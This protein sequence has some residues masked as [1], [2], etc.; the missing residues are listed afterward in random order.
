MKEK[1][2]RRADRS[3]LFFDETLADRQVAADVQRWFIAT[4][5]PAGTRPQLVRKAEVRGLPT[6]FLIGPDG[7][8]LDRIVGYRGAEQF[9]QRLR[10]AAG[11]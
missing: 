6:T 11:D 2:R 7:Q 10:L 9:C 8:I 3:P 1:R 5:V 4:A